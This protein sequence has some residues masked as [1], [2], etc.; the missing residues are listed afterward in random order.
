MH[1]DVAELEGP[2][3]DELESEL[4]RQADQLLAQVLE[5]RARLERLRE[6]VEASERQ[7]AGDEAML[8]QLHGLLGQSNQLSLDALD[9]HL[10]GQRLRE[11]AL[12]ILERRS[13]GG[14][15]GVHYREWYA[16]LREAGYTVSGRDPVATFLAQVSRSADVERV[17]GS[18]SGRYRSV[19]AS[20]TL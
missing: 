10:R 14:E 15:T 8:W 13:D 3:A 11:V 18:R 4:G 19:R 9:S 2:A 16:W 1:S 6:L 7:L 20:Q 12:D 5:G 17:G